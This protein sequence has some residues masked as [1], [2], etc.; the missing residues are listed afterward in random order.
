MNWVQLQLDL[1]QRAYEDAE[2]LD[3]VKAWLNTNM[4]EGS[5]ESIEEDSLNLYNKIKEMEEEY[6][7]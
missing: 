4:D 7:G 3:Y 1:R 6:Y 5:P 2:I